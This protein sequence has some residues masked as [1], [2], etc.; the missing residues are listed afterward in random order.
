MADRRRFDAEEVVEAA[1]QVFWERGYAGTAVDDLQAATGL[2]RSSLYLAFGTKRAVFDTALADYVATF[3]D[4]R[5]R[6][7]EARGAGLREAAAYFRWLA[8]YFG[9]A[10]ASRGCLYVN[11]ISE[12]AGRD[13]TFTPAATEFTDRV[14]AAF[15]NSVGDAAPEGTLDSARP[16]QRAAM[17]TAVFLGAWLDVRSNAAAAAAACLEIA[18]EITSWGPQARESV[19]VK[20]AE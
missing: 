18:N 20:S 10:D 1:K 16:S 6:P 19:G 7:L 11:S 8:E 9:G 13:P 12:L 2:S 3:V 5:L 17:L 14:R 4:P 15:R